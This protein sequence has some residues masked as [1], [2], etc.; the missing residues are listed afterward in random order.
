MDRVVYVDEKKEAIQELSFALQDTYEVIPCLNPRETVSLI[1]KYNPKAVLLEIALRG[2]S[3]F[4]VL[5]DLQKLP[6]PLPAMVISEHIDPLFV[7]RALKTGAQDYLS[8]PYTISMLTHRLKRLIASS[9]PKN[10]EKGEGYV[11][12]PLSIH[13]GSFFIGTSPFIQQ[14]RELVRFY[15]DSHYPVLIQGE[16][17][18]GKDLVARMLHFSSYRA[19]GP[20]EV[21]NVGAIP[22]SLLESELFGCEV[23]AFTDARQRKGCF[24]LA[25]NGTL[26]L[27]EIGNA[28][29]SLQAALLRVI[30]DGEVRRLGSTTS[31][32]VNTRIICATNK[33]LGEL[34]KK[35]K[36]R[37]DLRYRIAHLV[38]SLPPLRKRKE[39]IP[40]LVEYFLRN[41]A[42]P[43]ASI[44]SKALSF[45]Q[46]YHWPG[47]VRQLRACLERALLL[48]QGTHIE[49]GHISFE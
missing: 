40:L 41:S 45:L 36:F 33:D 18:T 26:F 32:F 23:G 14:V 39:D 10:L 6:H 48:C 13:K 35:G 15:A 37:D 16:S 21:R 27:D 19:H 12:R 47:N 28:S 2:Y 43:D 49:V 38:I 20:Y 46:D 11:K 24:E 30:E 29:D 7:V 44:S 25:H 1:K 22:L 8:R 4:Q 31:I 3:G 42:F 34:V 5:E 9:A 17:G